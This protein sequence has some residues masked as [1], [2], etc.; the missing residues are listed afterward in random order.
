MS[1][2]KSISVNK[3]AWRKLKTEATKTETTIADVVDNLI[4][5]KETQADAKPDDE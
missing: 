2:K 1:E 5:T 4:K 3:A